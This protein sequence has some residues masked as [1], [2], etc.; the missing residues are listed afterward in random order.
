MPRGT[1]EVQK[2]TILGKVTW[3]NQIDGGAKHPQMQ[4]G[5]CRHRSAS[6]DASLL[7][8]RG[9]ALHPSYLDIAARLVY[10]SF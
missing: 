1:S 5:F 10:A 6:G 9:H 2:D 4:G 7:K 3:Q 8:F